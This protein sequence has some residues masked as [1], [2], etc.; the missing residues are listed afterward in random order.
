MRSM[1]SAELYFH[2]M[3]FGTPSTSRC[4]NWRWNVFPGDDLTARGCEAWRLISN[5]ALLGLWMLITLEFPDQEV[6]MSTLKPLQID[7]VSDV[8]ARV[9]HRQTPDRERAGAGAGRAGRDQLAAV[10]SQFLGA[11]EA[12]AATNT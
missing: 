9:L 12:S 1:A 10:L 5:S 6:P 3:I 11:R 7:I 8:C 2:T 4:R